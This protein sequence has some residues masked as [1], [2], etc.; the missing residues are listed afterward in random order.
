MRFK[1]LVAIPLFSWGISSCSAPPTPPALPAPG[2]AQTAP[3]T[4]SPAPP[5]PSVAG[6]PAPALP[7]HLTLPPRLA[8]RE[9]SGITFEGVAFDAS[10]HRL[11]VV[12]QPGGPGSRYP[13]ARSATNAS[14]G[15]AGINA[16]FFTPE[17]TPLG[18]LITSGKPIGSW[19]RASSLGSGVF[20][21]STS[22]NLVIARREAVSATAP[23]RELLQAGPLL[24]EN[25]HPVSGLD[26]QKTA[27]RVLLVWTGGSQWWFGRTSAC[28]LAELAK[29]LD[30]GSP[31]GHSIRQA[32]NLDGGR[33]ADLWVSNKVSGGPLNRRP[34]WN[35]PVRN[36]FVLVP[37]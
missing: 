26:S 7:S 36:F 32:L 20:L 3:V 23:Q 1:A 16:G 27:V 37:R 2:K 12:D 11:A 25:D 24:I 35:R 33:S 4:S 15:L 22:G 29:A 14:H 10:S 13:D 18:K 31:T 30:Q 5:P 17:G 28:T 9:I 6:A 21:E 8:A 34:A 19:N